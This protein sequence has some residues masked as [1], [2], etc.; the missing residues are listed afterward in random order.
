[1]KMRKRKEREREKKG[2]QKIQLHEGSSDYQRNCAMLSTLASNPGDNLYY[3]HRN[4]SRRAN[5]P[6]MDGRT[7]DARPANNTTT[8]THE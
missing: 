6:R 1:M 5:D 3:T 7:S 8:N 4:R 2:D